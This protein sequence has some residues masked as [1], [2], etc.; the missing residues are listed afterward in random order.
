MEN[1][2]ELKDITYFMRYELLFV[3]FE[4]VIKR[5]LKLKLK[6]KTDCRT[7]KSLNLLQE[8]LKPNQISS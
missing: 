8:L 3:L 6:K 2:L 1:L 5:N 4:F 7:N